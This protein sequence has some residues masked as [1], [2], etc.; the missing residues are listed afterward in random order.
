MFAVKIIFLIIYLF[1]LVK[2]ILKK[3][4]TYMPFWI[5]PLFM[6]AWKGFSLLYLEQGVYAT[7]LYRKT[8]PIGTEYVFIILMT[9]FFAA[10][11]ASVKIFD[12]AL[13]TD[14]KETL[15]VSALVV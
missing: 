15:V 4:S 5:L 7:E 6:F 8:Y 10:A 9:I 14:G 12:N 11:I 1:F 2:I 3:E 13:Y